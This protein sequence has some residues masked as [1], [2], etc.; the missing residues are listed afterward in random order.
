M[1]RQRRNIKNGRI[2]R[3]FTT[4][5]PEDYAAHAAQLAASIHTSRTPQ[6]YLKLSARCS[7]HVLAVAAARKSTFDRKPKL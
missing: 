7:G 1:S 2:Q 6:G 5:Y 3:T 4:A